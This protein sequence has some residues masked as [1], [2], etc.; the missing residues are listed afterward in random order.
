MDV[1]QSS[2]ALFQPPFLEN[3]IQKVQWIDYSAVSSISEQS[4]IEFNIPGTSMD[5][6]DLRKTK[7]YL[8]F[9]ITKEDGTDIVYELDE[10][11]NPTANCDQVGPINFPINT[12]FRQVDVSL[13]QKVV[14]SEV[15]TNFPFK[16]IFDLLLNSSSDMLLSQAQGGLYHKDNAGSMDNASYVG[17]NLGYYK[18][19][20]LVRE[21]N[22]GTIEGYLYTDF[23]LDQDRLL[24]NGVALNI[25]LFQASNSFRLM[26]PSDK[27]YKVVI[28]NALL[29]VCQVSVNPSMILT[30]D[31]ALSKTP[32]IYPF[33][34]SDIKSFTIASGSRTF[35]TDNIYHGNVPSKIIVGMVSND[36]YSGNYNLNPF[37]FVHKNVNYLEVSVDGTPVPHRPFKPNFAENDYIPS[38]LSMFGHDLDMQEGITI[39]RSDYPLGYTFFIFD[40]QSYLNTDI[41]SKPIKG[42]VRLSLRF[43]SAL[44]IAINVLVY[45]KFPDVLAIDQS[46]Q[47]TLSNT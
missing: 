5:Y 21:G 16:C 3:G 18:R 2:L 47:V 36:A 25:K 38:Y 27:K 33:W 6:I 28:T 31:Q 32:A 42:H 22:V 40:L 20:T 7:L 29:K 46:R 37:N 17:T 34:R 8:Q 41:M 11:D 13:N 19:S 15:G 26:T 10:D 35:M 43:A 24:L 1:V 4:C 44:D 23:I 9:K 14:S 39:S 12:F 30:H 45:A